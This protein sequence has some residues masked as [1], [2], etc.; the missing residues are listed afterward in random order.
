MVTEAEVD[1]YIES[2]R[3]D[4]NYP[5]PQWSRDFWREQAEADK[6]YKAQLAAKAAEV[7]QAK[8][9]EAQ[10]IARLRKRI[11][12]LEQGLLT[13]D[14]FLIKAIGTAIGETH[15]QIDDRIDALESREPVPLP[16]P[17][18]NNPTMHYCGLWNAKHLYGPGAMVTYNGAGWIA[19]SAMAAGVRPGS[20]ET[21]WRLAVKSDTSALRPIVRD[22]VKRQLRERA[23]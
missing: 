7:V 21:G 23:R 13:Q 17:D 4:P 20:G 6:Q 16:L 18:W 10:E 3:P 15:R 1:R 11:A 19:M 2:H 22:E 12:K 5:Q 14:G 9:T 8:T